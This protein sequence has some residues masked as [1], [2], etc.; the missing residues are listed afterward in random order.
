M[1]VS[2]IR[3]NGCYIP[4]NEKETL[5]A[6]KVNYDAQ[7]TYIQICVYLGY[8]AFLLNDGT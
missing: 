4:D 8:F 7:M 6:W 1:E 2:F 5:P 3:L